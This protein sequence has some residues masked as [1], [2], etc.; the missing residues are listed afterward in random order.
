[1]AGYST[2]LI[3]NEEHGILVAIEPYCGN[4][5]NVSGLRALAPQPLAG[6]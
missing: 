4:L 2:N 6:P 1:M 3:D 5:L